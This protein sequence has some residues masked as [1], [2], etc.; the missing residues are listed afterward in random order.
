MEW[1]ETGVREKRREVFIE[2]I[3]NMKKANTGTSCLLIKIPVKRLTTQCVR[4]LSLSSPE[5]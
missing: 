3:L 1:E 4:Q 5:L 2:G